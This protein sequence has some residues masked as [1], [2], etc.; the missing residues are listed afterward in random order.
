MQE[1]RQLVGRLR[2]ILRDAIPRS[3]WETRLSDPV[4]AMPVHLRRARAR[5][6][7][8]DLAAR[9]GWQREIERDLL[10]LGVP[11]LKYLSQ[12]QL[13]QVLVRLKGLEDCL[14]NICDPP[15]GPPAR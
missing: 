4:P 5:Y 9:Y 6:E 10:R 11:S 15:D 14:Q 8:Q 12:E 7:I 3:H 1:Q 13:D 2:A